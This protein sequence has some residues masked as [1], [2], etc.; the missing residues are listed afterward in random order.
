[1]IVGKMLTKVFY[2][3]L[4]KFYKEKAS[5]FKLENYSRALDICVFE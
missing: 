3:S 2:I 5:V 1:M 4:R